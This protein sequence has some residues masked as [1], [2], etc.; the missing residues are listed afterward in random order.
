MNVC[1][2]CGASRFY[3]DH[4]AVVRRYYEHDGRH[5]DDTGV[6]EVQDVDRDVDTLKC[7][8]CRWEGYSDDLVPED[9]WED[10]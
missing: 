6:E 8:E 1:P 3:A 4:H 9:E 5:L 2:D 7:D 10:Q